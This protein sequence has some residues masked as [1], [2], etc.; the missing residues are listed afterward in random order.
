MAKMA[1]NGLQWPKWRKWPN[2]YTAFTA[3]QTPGESGGASALVRSQRRHYFFL[4]IYHPHS[5]EDPPTVQILVYNPEKGP[6]GPKRGPKGPK[7][8]QKGPKGQNLPKIL[9]IL[10]ENW[11]GNLKFRHWEAQLC[12][13]LIPAAAYWSKMTEPQKSPKLPEKTPPQMGPKWP[14]RAQWDHFWPFWIT[15]P[16]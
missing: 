3:P 11:P 16:F 1:Q 14:K 4:G 13:W 7:R 15:R 12:A 2:T 9:S 8:P 10:H 5:Q 6:K